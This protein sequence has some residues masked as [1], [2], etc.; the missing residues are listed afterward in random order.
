[1]R[2]SYESCL[3]RAKHIVSLDRGLAPSGWDPQAGGGSPGKP[4]AP[5]APPVKDDAAKSARTLLAKRSPK[6]YAS[7]I[8]TGGLGNAS[9]GGQGSL[10]GGGF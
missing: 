1:M 9:P 6:G 3:K 5:P 10:L 4:P 2:E 7:T 8:L